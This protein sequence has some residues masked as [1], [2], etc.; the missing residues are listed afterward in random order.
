MVIFNSV[1]FEAGSYVPRLSLN[2]KEDE[3]DLLD[4]HLVP[5]EH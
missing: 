5:P 4:L 2:I 1:L 3:L